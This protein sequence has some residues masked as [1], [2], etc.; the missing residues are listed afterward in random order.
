MVLFEKSLLKEFEAYRAETDPL[1]RAR[2]AYP[3]SA[4]EREP[5]FLYLTE[6][7]VSLRTSFS[8]IR[9]LLRHTELSCRG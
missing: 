7:S 6:T 1:I 9:H 3:L 8:S 4:V 2:I 5:D